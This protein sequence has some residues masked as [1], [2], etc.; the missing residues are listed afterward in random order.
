MS[1]NAD[2]EQINK[3]LTRLATILDGDDGL[4]LQ[5][6]MSQ[7]D[8][9]GKLMTVLDARISRSDI[10]ARDLKKTLATL[11]STVSNLSTTVEVLEDERDAL[12]NQIKGFRLAIAALSSG[13]VILLVGIV[14][15]MWGA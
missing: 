13:L 4:G 9:L 5:G 2:L 12:K 3:S 14:M 6:L 10:V 15:R 1:D 8:D 11:E 7:V